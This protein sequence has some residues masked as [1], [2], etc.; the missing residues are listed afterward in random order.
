MIKNLYYKFHVRVHRSQGRPGKSGENVENLKNPGKPGKFNDISWKIIALWENS[1]KLF[2]LPFNLLILTDIWHFYITWVISLQPS[3][4]DLKPVAFLHFFHHFYHLHMFEITK[5]K[6]CTARKVLYNHCTL[7][8]SPE[9]RSFWSKLFC[10]VHCGLKTN[11]SDMFDQF[12]I[13]L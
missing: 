12:F 9:S 8:C 2:Q 4:R 13:N 3:R 10:S 7:Q 11:W 6:Y 1:G 5:E